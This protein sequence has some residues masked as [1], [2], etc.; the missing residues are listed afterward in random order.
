MPLWMP[1]HG[2]ARNRARTNAATAESVD[3]SCLGESVV[4]IDALPDTVLARI[5]ALVDC[6]RTGVKLR[7]VCRRW[8]GV[9][10]HLAQVTLDLGWADRPYHDAATDD[11]LVMVLRNFSRAASL[12][13]RHCQRITAAGFAAIGVACPA[14]RQLSLYGCGVHV[15]G[16]HVTDKA[17]ASIFS[18]WNLLQIID[19]SGCVELTDATL[20][21]AGQS[22]PR[23]RQINLFN[24]RAVSDAGIAALCA[25]CVGLETVKL[26][27]CVALMDVELVYIGSTL[28]QLHELKLRHCKGIK[29]S[30]LPSLLRGCENLLL[31]NLEAAT[32]PPTG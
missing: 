28:R 8:A 18:K 11:V 10:R 4:S 31:L 14:L 16:V 22:C 9:T 6:A 20:E 1:H 2:R 13:L 27:W 26:S 3:A 7:G 15:T 24:C 5:F 30:G 32:G 25:G 19:L 23:L 29:G 17:M 21:A 12:S